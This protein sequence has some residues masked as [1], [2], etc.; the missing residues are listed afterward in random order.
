MAQSGRLFIF[1]G[2]D[3]AGKTSVSAEFVQ[4][5]QK[6][7]WSARTVAFPGKTPNTLGALVYRLHH[8]PADCGVGSLTAASL[9]TMHIAAHLDAIETVILP[10]LKRGECIVLDRYWWST[11]VYG[12]VGGM[13]R[14]V[15]DALIE[16]ERLAWAEWRPARIFYIER[17]EPLR[18]EPLDTWR[19]LKA[20]YEALVAL[21]TGKYPIQVNQ[22][23]TTPEAALRAA[24]SQVIIPPS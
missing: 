19:K 6:Q 3:G 9:Q 21:E 11:W 7:S 10:A 23:Q 17:T 22:N 18:P 12:L 14:D 13:Q 5:L 15:L 24:L 16:V 1:E 4:S 20:A 2:A 8:N